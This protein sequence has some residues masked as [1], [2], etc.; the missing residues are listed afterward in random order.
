MEDRGMRTFTFDLDGDGILTAALNVPGR[1][2][3]TITHEVSAD[4]TTL[5][6]RVKGDA[7]IRGLVVTSGKSNGFCAGADL[8]EQY[9]ANV[10]APLSAEA[11]IK[12]ELA[13]V[14]D[15]KMRFRAL[16]T[17]GKPAFIGIHFFS[18][19]DRMQLVEVIRGK[20]TSDETLARTLD[21]VMKLRKT[22]IVVRDSRGFYTSRTFQTY[23]EEGFEMLA[24]GVAPAIIE[25]IGRATGMPRGPLEISDDVGLDLCYAAR[26]QARA[27]LGAAFRPTAQDGLLSRLVEEQGRFGRKNGKG[28]YEYPTDGGP[29]R[30]SKDLTVSILQTLSRPS[31]QECENLK[32]RLLY[33][34]SLEAARIFAEGVIN[35][36][37]DADVGA[38]LGW[39][40][41]AWTGG[42]LSLIDQVGA[43]E[44][45]RHCDVLAA[46]YG[47]RFAPPE[48]LR[49]MATRG[50]GYYNLSTTAR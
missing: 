2:M 7:A 36:P 5:I 15:L 26:R 32:R 42:P 38:L 43:A 16:E 10:G 4:F 20:R 30:L 28:C 34:Q 8:G 23:L 21:F 29:K 41:P 33:R 50:D 25:N 9:A 19:V 6:E 12:A 22:P 44:F 49:Q 24:E 37:R 39:G 3:N 47:D 27:D 40:F 1:S 46:K 48:Q 13:R 17:C 14:S 11:A 31:A 18:P 45:V 35:D